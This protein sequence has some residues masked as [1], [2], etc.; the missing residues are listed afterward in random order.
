M[1]MQQE[2]Y[3]GAEY[4][5]NAAPYVTNNM[6][7]P[8]GYQGGIA[9]QRQMVPTQVPSGYPAYALPG[10]R[11]PMRGPG[12]SQ[13]M[14]GLQYG[15]QQP[16]M[17]MGASQPQMSMQAYGSHNVNPAAAGQYPRQA[18]SLS[19]SNVVRNNPPGFVQNHQGCHM[20]ESSQRFM[21]E[22]RYPSSTSMTPRYPGYG[23]P[24]QS[25]TAVYDPQHQTAHV[26]HSTKYYQQRPGYHSNEGYAY[27]P[28][29]NQLQ[30]NIQGSNQLSDPMVRHQHGYPN[31]MNNTMS[32]SH[33]VQMHQNTSMNQNQSYGTVRGSIQPNTHPN[34]Y[35]MYPHYNNQQP[36]GMIQPRPQ[37]SQMTTPQGR[38]NIRPQLNASNSVAAQEQVR[39]FNSQ[40]ISTNV[41]SQQG[42]SNNLNSNQLNAGNSQT[43]FRHP[44]TS[45]NASHQHMYNMSTEHSNNCQKAP[46]P[47]AVQFAN[48]V[49]APQKQGIVTQMP[50]MGF[51]NATPNMSMAPRLSRPNIPE[52]FNKLNEQQSHPTGAPR[53]EVPY[54]APQDVISLRDS[55][56]SVSSVTYAESPLADSGSES[57]TH[58]EDE[59]TNDIADGPVN[60][61]DSIVQSHECQ[62]ATE[63]CVND[64]QEQEMKEETSLQRHE[65][66]FET[67]NEQTPM[68][69]VDD[70]RNDGM[71]TINMN[72]SANQ[73]NQVQ[74]IIC[75]PQPSSNM[76][77]FNQ[78]SSTSSTSE[79]LPFN[80]TENKDCVVVPWGWKR[81]VSSDIVVYVR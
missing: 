46:Y 19:F 30:H 6:Q 25:M 64:N 33:G 3:S 42:Y 15:S 5:P 39:Y 38:M 59:V 67:E 1:S 76:F 24:N 18:A 8:N 10:A 75:P 31:T 2:M 68:N 57:I 44:H 62:E 34:Q 20:P 21:A 81:L 35:Q 47:H 78:A 45:Q 70:S 63:P 41:I 60:I 28:Q 77:A 48:P 49:H 9:G 71:V 65:P 13:V 58:H 43:Y 16:G 22:A 23:H 12:P 52:N 51:Q 80:P 29:S 17:Q 69:M 56:E 26:P 74:T 14:Q 40:D 50:V 37:T 32:T 54:S 61:P 79:Q 4:A 66:S 55:I 73:N 11:F 72:P 7:G 53:Q 36:G 27:L